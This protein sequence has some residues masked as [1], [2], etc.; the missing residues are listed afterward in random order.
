M[1]TEIVA[2]GL[3]HCEGPLLTQ[4]G[5]IAVAS[6]SHGCVYRIEG[7]VPV[8]HGDTD[9]GPNGLVETAS[10]EILAAQLGWRGQVRPGSRL[11]GGI[12]AVAVDGAVRWITQ[13]PVSPNDLCL[14]PDG[15]LYF[16]D[17]SRKPFRDG[18]LW[19]CDVESGEAQILFSLPW[20]PNGIGF[21]LESD[22]LYVADT[23]GRRIVRYPFAPGGRLGPEET[24]CEIPYGM[25]DGFAFDREGTLVVCSVDLDN[26]PGEIQTFDR[27]GALLARHRPGPSSLYTNVA[28]DDSG[29]AFVT[30]TET[31]QLLAIKGLCGP[32]L[33]LFPFR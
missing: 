1:E 31:G 22:A 27:H 5:G 25:P 19:R 26:N 21:G 16:T 30:E 9:G 29:M 20:Y 33:P 6:M 12:Q 24:F 13:D 11:T 23:S 2:S 7:G 28:I 10:G 17:P 14:G 18:R 32:G 4:A 3:G 15:L 8:V